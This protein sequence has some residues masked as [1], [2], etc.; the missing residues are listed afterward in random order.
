MNRRRVAFAATATAAALTVGSVSAYAAVAA[1]RIATLSSVCVAA[2][3]ARTLTA[4]SAGRCARGST[5]NR[6]PVGVRGLTGPAG[7]PGP[8]GPSGAAGA[9]GATKV[10]TVTRTQSVPTN[11]DFTDEAI[12]PFGTTLT[13][14][15][16]N[17]TSQLVRVIGSY[18][19]TGET[20][21]GHFYN[22]G[23]ATVSTAVYALCATP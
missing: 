19:A 12:C 21:V 13:G 16:V 10:Q 5:L 20:W 2:S 9:P 22:T 14:G 6:L 3:T 7:A 4:P 15:G 23:P 11:G 1:T 17:A 18:P 8:A